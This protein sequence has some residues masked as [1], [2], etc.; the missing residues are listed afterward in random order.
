MSER[1]NVIV[2]FTDQQ[3]WDTTGETAGRAP[4]APSPPSPV[5]LA[6]ETWRAGEQS[7]SAL[8][9]MR[10]LSQAKPR[11]PFIGWVADLLYGG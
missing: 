9:G 2:C 6:G 5:A 8:A 10:S 4:R 3:R 7:Q 11:N 1:P